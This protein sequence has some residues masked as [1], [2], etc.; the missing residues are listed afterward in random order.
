MVEYLRKAIG[1]S[2]TGRTSEKIVFVCFGAGDNGK[3]TLLT[4]IRESLPSIR[5]SSRS[6][7]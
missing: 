1:Y 3:T 4:T 6:I 5:A 7:R 2:L